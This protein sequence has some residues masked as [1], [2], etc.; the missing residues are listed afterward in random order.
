ML[1]LRERVAHLGCLTV[2]K[3]WVARVSAAGEISMHGSKCFSSCIRFCLETLWVHP[4][5]EIA[6]LFYNVHCLIFLEVVD[7]R[8]MLGRAVVFYLTVIIH[9][10]KHKLHASPLLASPDSSNFSLKRTTI[11]EVSGSLETYYDNLT[12]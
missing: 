10:I 2:G 4:S 3:V 7:F 12:W 9:M 8:Y 11:G 5:F 1:H 6:F